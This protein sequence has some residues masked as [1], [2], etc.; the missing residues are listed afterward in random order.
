[1]MISASNKH[2]P[3][4]QPRQ[5]V[6]QS[7]ARPMAAIYPRQLPFP[8]PFVYETSRPDQ[9]PSLGLYYIDIKIGRISTDCQIPAIQFAPESCK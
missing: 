2:S 6:S 8:P 4:R 3:P 7:H 9:K 1:M 5:S